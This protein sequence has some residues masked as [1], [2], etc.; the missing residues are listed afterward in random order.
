M[1]NSLL[2]FAHVDQTHVAIYFVKRKKFIFIPQILQECD[3]YSSRITF[4]D[5]VAPTAMERWEGPDR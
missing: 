3:I 5:A 1:K 4:G 2:P